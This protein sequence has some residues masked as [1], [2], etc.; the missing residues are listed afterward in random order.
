MKV[1]V[2]PPVQGPPEAPAA[3]APA[4]PAAPAPPAPAAPA[5]AAPAP[6]APAPPA[7]AAPAAPAPAAPAAPV[8]PVVYTLTAPEG[9]YVDPAD[10]AG[11]EAVARQNE[12]TNEEAQALVQSHHDAVVAQAERFK[13]ETTA[14]PTYGGANLEQTQ[15]LA[16]AALDRFAPAGDPLGDALRRDLVKTGYG[17]KLA[18]VSFLA[19][20]GK[21]MAEDRPA[22]GTGGAGGPD[23]KDPAAVLYPNM[24]P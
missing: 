5:A 11:F 22:Q 23:K 21:A 18:T 4:A 10:L 19:R 16:K 3:P 24:K 8:A 6:A 1:L 20:I 17:N 9:G 7:A 12:L 14:H 2:A 15:K 13:A